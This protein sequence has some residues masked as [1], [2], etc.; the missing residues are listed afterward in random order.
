MAESITESTDVDLDH[1]L[2]QSWQSVDSEVT[3]MLSNLFAKVRG[4]N[5]VHFFSKYHISSR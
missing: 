4:P 2:D 1:D 3:E 5:L